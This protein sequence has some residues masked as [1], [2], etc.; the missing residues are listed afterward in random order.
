MIRVL[1]V[2]D[3]AVL[4]QSLKFILESDP[5][6]KVVSEAHNGE[7]AVALTGRLQPDV[8]TMDIWMPRA[9]GFPV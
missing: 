7:E 3:S 2:D 5:E 6:L 1:G 8:I 4:R 9:G